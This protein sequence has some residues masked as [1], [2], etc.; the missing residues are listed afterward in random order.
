MNEC[1]ERDEVYSVLSSIAREKFNL[2]GSFEF[3]L[4][5]L[6]DVND[7]VSRIPA[8]AVAPVRRGRWIGEPNC[9]YR[10]SECGEHYPS[11]RGYIGYNYCPS[12]GAA[13]SQEAAE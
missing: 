4:K 1:V 6:L 10:C 9:W 12:C 11:L 5:A 7:A 2:S 13:M 8:A 3:Y